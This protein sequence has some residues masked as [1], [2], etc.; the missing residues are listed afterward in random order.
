[1][2]ASPISGL[3]LS[4]LET[5]EGETLSFLAISFIVTCSDDI[6]KGFLSLQRYA[7]KTSSAKHLR[8]RFRDCCDSET[9]PYFFGQVQYRYCEL[10]DNQPYTQLMTDI[11][12]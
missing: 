1:L 9:F 2:V 8:K 7:G 11:M 3:S 6:N 10:S 4:A 12:V 5:V